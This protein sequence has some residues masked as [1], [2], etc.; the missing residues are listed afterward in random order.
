MWEEGSG[1]GAEPESQRW[2]R[3]VSQLEGCGRLVGVRRLVVD[4]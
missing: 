2:S 4:K 1:E 3:M